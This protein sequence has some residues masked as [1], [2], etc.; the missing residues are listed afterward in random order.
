MDFDHAA[1]LAYIQSAMTQS[2]MMVYSGDSADSRPQWD[3][4]A[5]GGVLFDLYK[6][7][8]G[9]E[10]TDVRPQKQLPGLSGLLRHLQTH[11]DA[12]FERI[13]ETQRR[14]V[15]FGVPI[16]LGVGKP[17]CTDVRM[18]LEACTATPD[19]Y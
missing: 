15:H 9:K 3:L 11:S 6:R 8:L 14:N 4:D 7:E 2:Q 16:D 5:E 17:T 10:K 12:L 13:S 18:V 19:V 1:I